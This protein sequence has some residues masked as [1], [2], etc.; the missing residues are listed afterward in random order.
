MASS[1][2]QRKKKGRVLTA[3]PDAFM[4]DGIEP[5]SDCHVRQ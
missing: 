5:E 1:A 2:G 3:V 4:A